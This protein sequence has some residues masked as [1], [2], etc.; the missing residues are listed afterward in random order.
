MTNFA[1]WHIVMLY[2]VYLLVEIRHQA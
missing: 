1:M 2:I